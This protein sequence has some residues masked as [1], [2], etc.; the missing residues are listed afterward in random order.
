[1]STFRRRIIYKY[2]IKDINHY[3]VSSDKRVLSPGILFRQWDRIREFLRDTLGLSQAEREVVFRLLRFWVR[4]DT[5]Y[6]KESQITHDPGC[7]KATYWRTIKKLQDSGLIH[8][9]NRFIIREKAQI[10]NQYLL[11]KLVLIIARYLAEHGAKFKA[12][13]LQPYL[14]I[15]GADF[16]GMVKFWEDGTLPSQVT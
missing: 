4:Y 9:I 6:P 5:V 7:S 15:S 13:F 12:R 2:N 16:W 11:H 3:G 8:I 10:S 1:M 14:K